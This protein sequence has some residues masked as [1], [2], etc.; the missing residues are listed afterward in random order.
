M[1][2]TGEYVCAHNALKA[3]ALAYRI[4]N[5]EFRKRQNGLIG[6]AE[7]YPAIYSKNNTDPL[8]E[9][10]GYAFFARWILDPIFSAKGN[11]P[12]LMISRVAYRSRLLGLKKTRL[13][14]FSKYW[15]DCIRCVCVCVY[16]DKWYDNKLNHDV[17]D[18]FFI[19]VY[20]YR[21]SADFL[22]LNHY[23]SFLVERQSEENILE[24]KNDMGLSISSDPSWPTTEF[25]RFLVIIH[26]IICI[27]IIVFVS[28]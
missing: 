13:P 10:I 3:H 7:L 20:I 4:Y 15:I 5:L 24:W 23:T 12:E 16:I 14:V 11:Y 9:D 6:I 26:F 1:N 22:G 21:G 18:F 8:A 27:A 28:K 17:I 19:Y 2:N 25:P